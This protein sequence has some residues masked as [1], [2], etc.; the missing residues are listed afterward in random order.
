[1]NIHHSWCAEIVKGSGNHRRLAPPACYL[2]RLAGDGHVHSRLGWVIEYAV[3]PGS[4]HDSIVTDWVDT[5]S[6][7]KS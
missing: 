7:W 3:G 1:M 4:R 5:G 6:R 2:A